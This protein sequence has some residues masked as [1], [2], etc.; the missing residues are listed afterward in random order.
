MPFRALFL[1]ALLLLLSGC[2][3]GALVYPTTSPPIEH[4]WIGVEVGTYNEPYRSWA[5]TKCTEVMARWGKPDQQSVDGRVTT[6]VY[7]KGFAWAGILPIIGVPIPFVIPVAQKS[8][9]LACEND[10]VMSA[11]G[12]ATGYSG[13]YCGLIS[14][15]V[16][17]GCKTDTGSF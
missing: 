1:C 5:P 17:W 14:E 7:K 11:S 12:T 3:G 16:K 8:T 13:A 9:I 10:V 2:I 15:A 6:L 4:P